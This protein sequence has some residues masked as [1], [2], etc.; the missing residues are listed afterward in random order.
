MAQVKPLRQA[1]DFSLPDQDGKIHTL[2]DFTGRWVVLYFYPKDDTPGCTTE[3]CNFRDARDAIAQ[4][5]N[6]TVIGI[7][8]DTVKAHKKFVDK[9]S[10]NFTLLADPEHTTID[11]YGA[12]QQKSMFGR[13][14]MGIQRSTIIINPE[15]QIVKQYPKVD[16]S[17]HAA[18]IISDL[19]RLQNSNI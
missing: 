18:E 7:S 15:S 19:S 16:P 12:W 8:K 9:Y 4:Y 5:G 2:H 17:K 13:K 10:L 1:P 14:Y 6:A 11:A 3:A